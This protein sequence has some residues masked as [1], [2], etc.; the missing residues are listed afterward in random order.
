M[1]TD[2][3]PTTK[4]MARYMGISKP[5][6]MFRC[7]VH[8]NFLVPFRCICEKVYGNLL[9]SVY[10]YCTEKQTKISVHLHCCIKEHWRDILTT[11]RHSEVPF[12][13]LST[14]RQ[15]V[16]SWLADVSETEQLITVNLPTK[17]VCIY[18]VNKF[19][20]W[21]FLSAFY[22]VIRDFFAKFREWD[23]VD[24]SKTYDSVQNLLWDT[25][26]PITILTRQL[27]LVDLWTKNLKKQ[28][29]SIKCKKM[30]WNLLKFWGVCMCLSS[31]A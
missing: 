5:S 15:C 3:Y 24:I 9:V 11:Y 12:L 29:M 7:K 31:A 20:K 8:G 27:S 10:P 25:Q 4:Y 2:L 1:Q 21:Q 30:L 23:E 26:N 14:L 22:S 18:S 17:K 13:I 28:H 6:H 16:Y 19:K